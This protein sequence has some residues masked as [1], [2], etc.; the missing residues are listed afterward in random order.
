MNLVP[1]FGAGRTTAVD[2]RA[3]CPAGI[4]SLAPRAV[5]VPKENI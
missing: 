1:V 3:V 2:T 4:I 5:R